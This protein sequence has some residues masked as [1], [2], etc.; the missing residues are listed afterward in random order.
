MMFEYELTVAP[1]PQQITPDVDRTFYWHGKASTAY[2][3]ANIGPL[4]GDFGA[5]NNRNIDLVRIATAV[6][7]A[8]RS[9][10]RSGSLSRWN[11]RDISL[12]V[13]VL[14]ATPWNDVRCDLER[15]LGFLT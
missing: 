11:Q 8:D 12:T 6:L 1:V 15:L 2:F 14:A 10:T 13:D 7:A 3:K 9:A 5:V 4:L